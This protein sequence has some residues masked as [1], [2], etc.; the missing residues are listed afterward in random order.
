[1]AYFEQA[2][3]ATAVILLP[4]LQLK[5]RRAGG[6]VLENEV[7]EFLMGTFGGYTAAAGNIFGYWKDRAGEEWYGEHRQFS[8]ALAE[9]TAGK[10][11]ELK[12]FL[13][14][15]AGKLGEQC[16]YLETAGRAVLVYPTP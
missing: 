11:G 7:H 5:E 15:L 10:L 1:M 14:Q 8:V 2:L 16:I 13:G 6:T 9:D 12:E 3:G 4:S